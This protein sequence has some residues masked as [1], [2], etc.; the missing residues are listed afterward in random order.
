MDPLTYTAGPVLQMRSA[1]CTK[2]L[3]ITVMTSATAPA[4]PLD[5]STVDTVGFASKMK[6]SPLVVKST[7]LLLTSR[8]PLP[9][10]LLSG[11]M[12]CMIEDEIHFAGAVRPA[13]RCK[14]HTEWLPGRNPCP[15]SRMVVPPSGGPFDGIIST[16]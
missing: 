7:P 8:V 10:T 1:D 16:T 13:C 11:L 4:D 2:W 14:R 6:L 9:A 3:P 15:R 12:H 5:G